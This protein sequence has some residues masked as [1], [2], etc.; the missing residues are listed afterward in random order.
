[1]PHNVA[2]DS[3]GLEGFAALGQNLHRLVDAGAL[4]FLVGH[5]QQVSFVA[6]D[7]RQFHAVQPRDGLGQFQSIASRPR[8]HPVQTDVHLD[9]H[10][11]GDAPAAARF[12]QRFHLGEVI[13][14]DDG[15][16]MTAER[17]HAFPL[18]ATDDHVGHQDVTDAGSGHHLGFRHLGAGDAHCAGIQLHDG[19]G[20]RLVAFL[21]RPPFLPPLLN[22]ADHLVDV[23]FHHFQVDAQD[24]GVEIKLMHA[25]HALRHGTFPFDVGGAES[26]Y[27]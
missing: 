14:G 3:I 1:M 5:L 25:D 16:G 11:A 20:G 26:G 15:V 23:G 27:S 17:R 7:A 9:H 21:V 18:G 12:R 4:F 8:S 22:V 13:A 24:G 2:G 10:A 6:H 19:N